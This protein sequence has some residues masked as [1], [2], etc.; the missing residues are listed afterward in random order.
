MK[1][2][3]IYGAI[4]VTINNGNTNHSQVVEEEVVGTSTPSM[5]DDGS[6]DGTFINQDTGEYFAQPSSANYGNIGKV[7]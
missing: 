6:V 3:I 5:Y 1:L 4:V 2:K 7:E